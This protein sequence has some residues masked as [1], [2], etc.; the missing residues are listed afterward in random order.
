MGRLAFRSPLQ[1]GWPL[2]RLRLPHF[3]GL[4]TQKGGTTTLQ[5]LLEKHPGVYLPPCKEVHY[6]SLHAEQPPSW[7][8][9]H[10]DEARWRQRRGDITPFYL[11]HPNAPGHIRALLPQAQLIVLL[12]DPV[13][14]ALSQVFHARRNGFEPLEVADA[15]AA[16]P[17][18]L[19]SGSAYSFQKHSYLA[20]SRYLEQ[21]D[22]YEVLFPPQQLLVLKSE[23]FFTDTVAVW[24]RI[25]RFLQL[26]PIPLPMKL[27]RSNA[28][29]GEAE[30]VI[31]PVRESLKRSLAATAS[32]VKQR[33]G[34]DWGWS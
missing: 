25:Q 24:I 26:R 27:P 4:G 18:R 10:Y 6:F 20:R 13:E 32:G 5:K 28:G 23:D 12:R 22:R 33:Y 15:L 2:R 11:F 19:A 34:I 29:R 8:S 31:E 3:L 7:Y 14:R 16:E 30:T 17:E 9:A 21:L 1:P